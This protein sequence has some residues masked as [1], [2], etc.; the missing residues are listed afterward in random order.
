ME[1]A[2]EKGVKFNKDK[3]SFSASSIFC[4]GH[5][6]GADGMKLDSEKVRAIK[7]MPR[8]QSCKELLTLLGKLNHPTKYIPNL[9]TRNKSLQDI[10]KRDPFSRSPKN[11]Q[12]LA[13]LKLSI[14]SGISFFNYKSLNVE[15]KVNASS[16]GL[17]ANLSGR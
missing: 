3:C 12:M 11:D 17:G 2:L 5:L 4:F 9:S 16:H 6:I 1:R 13:E 7:E 15:L 14:V 10:L 8:P